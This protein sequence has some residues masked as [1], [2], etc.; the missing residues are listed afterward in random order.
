[1][2]KYKFDHSSAF[3]CIYESDISRSKMEAVMQFKPESQFYSEKQILFYSNDKDLKRTR[4][5][6]NF[7]TP[8]AS[9]YSGGFVLEDSMIIPRPCAFKSFNLT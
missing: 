3:D 8:Y 7:F 2:Y 1:L 5:P 6:Q 4:T 9:K